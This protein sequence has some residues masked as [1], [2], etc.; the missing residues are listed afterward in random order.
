M[1]AA[2]VNFRDALKA[3]IY[4]LFMALPCV[5]WSTQLFMAGD[6]TM[7]EKHPKDYPETGWGM[8]FSHFFNEHLRVVNLAKNGRS[9]RTFIEEGL[10]QQIIDN[11]KEGDFVIIQF[12]HNDEVVKK[13]DRYTTPEQF[14]ENLTDMISQV[15]EKGASAI[16]LS[17]VT[18]R[19]FDDAGK[20]ELTHPYS[21]LV[22]KIA[23]QTKVT[24]IDMDSISRAY[25]ETQGDVLSSLRFM[26]IQPG[27]HPN[28]PNGVKDNTHFNQLGARE[29]AQLVLVE[30]RKIQ[31]PLLDFLRVPDPKHLTLHY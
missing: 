9:T 21:E 2:I 16:L 1:P 28:Y 10:W 11:L 24:F 12:G 6:S 29:I 20:I 14:S 27:L 22:Y 18:R 19:Y 8:P 30:L 31:H 25:F 3:I 26:H 7:A 23:K 4:M 17:P 13:K 15:R 5:A